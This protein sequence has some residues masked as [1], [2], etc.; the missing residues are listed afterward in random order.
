MILFVGDK[1]YKVTGNIFLA[2]TDAELEDVEIYEGQKVG[3]FTLDEVN[4]LKN[5]SLGM[6][7]FLKS[8][9]EILG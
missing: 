8:Y 9:K 3:Y 5:I 1:S 7:A 6:P 4:E 2:Y